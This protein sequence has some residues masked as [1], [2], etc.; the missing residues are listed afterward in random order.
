MDGESKGKRKNTG[1]LSKDLAH[2]QN[3]KGLMVHREGAFSGIQ[4]CLGVLVVI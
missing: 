3:A 4:Q 2:R 1:V